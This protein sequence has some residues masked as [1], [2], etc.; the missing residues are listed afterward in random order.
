MYFEILE[1]GEIVKATMKDEII[2]VE[3]E[4][5]NTNK[6]ELP[7]L[8]IAAICSL[9]GIGLMIYGKKKN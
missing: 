5:P 4:V 9:L 3:V 6:D 8:P 1:D 7:I 2:P